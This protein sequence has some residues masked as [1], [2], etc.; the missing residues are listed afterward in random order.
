M[1]FVCPRLSLSDRRN[2]RQSKLVPQSRPVSIYEHEHADATCLSPG[3]RNNDCSPHLRGTAE[4]ILVSVPSLEL[5]RNIRGRGHHIE[6]AAILSVRTGAPPPRPRCGP[7]RN[8]AT[9]DGGITQ[10][11][12]SF[13]FVL[14]LYMRFLYI[15]RWVFS[16]SDRSSHNTG[17]LI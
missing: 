13:F 17:S 14:A 16:A 3:R 4:A 2:S 8:G 9:R 7:S 1:K 11:R 10:P 15:S 5:C 12:P 6:R